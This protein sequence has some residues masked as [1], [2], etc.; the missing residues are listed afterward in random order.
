MVQAKA[1]G[2]GFLSHSFTADPFAL[3]ALLSR[4]D[5]HNAIGEDF[6]LSLKKSDMIKHLRRHEMFSFI[7]FPKLEWL[8]EAFERKTYRHDQLVL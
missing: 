4:T 6:K 1:T 7:P 3:V 2:N 8:A 5:L